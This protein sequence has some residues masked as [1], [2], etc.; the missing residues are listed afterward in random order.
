MA[1]NFLTISSLK[2]A[3]AEQLAINKWHETTPKW[4]PLKI[5]WPS[6]RGTEYKILGVTEMLAGLLKLQIA[7]TF[8]EFMQ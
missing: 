2:N 1:L 8:A 6:L 5:K 7:D 4:L 3:Q